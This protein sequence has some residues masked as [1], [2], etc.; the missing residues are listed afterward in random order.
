MGYICDAKTLVIRNII[1]II[2]IHNVIDAVASIVVT[3]PIL[4]IKLSIFWCTYSEVTFFLFCSQFFN[5]KS[6]ISNHNF[7][8]HANNIQTVYPC[9]N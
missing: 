3:M 5:Y 4:K 8:T 2:I 7:G 6:I 9:G 1:I